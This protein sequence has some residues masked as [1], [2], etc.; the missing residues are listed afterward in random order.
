MTLFSRNAGFISAAEQARLAGAKVAIAGV[1]GDGGQTAVT[2]ARMGVTR[3][4]LADPEA[5][6]SENT[7]RQAGCSVTTIGHNKAEVIARLIEHINP[8]AQIKVFSEGVTESNL[9]SF[10]EDCSIVVDETDYTK[11]NIGVMLARAARCRRLAVIMGVNLGFG[12]IVT[13]FQPNGMTFERYLGL[14]DTDP[15]AAFTEQS[16][17]LRRWIPRLPSYVDLAVLAK[18]Q[19]GGMPAPSVAP[20][21]LLAAGAITTEV[22]NQLVGR[23]KPLSAPKAIWVDALERKSKIIRY[24]AVSFYLSVAELTIRHKLG[25]NQG[26]AV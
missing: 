26:L 2:L 13:S 17:A 8:D 18:V 24:P 5:F 20:G 22:F 14:K 6:E 4:A 15:L 1:G 16:V 3:F 19:A 11:P 10:L 25:L 21:V 7:N 23:R 12:A 9:S